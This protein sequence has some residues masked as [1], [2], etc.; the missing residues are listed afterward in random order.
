MSEKF[1]LDTNAFITPY[2]SFYDP[3]LVPSFWKAFECVLVSHKQVAVLDLVADEILKGDDSLRQWFDDLVTN[4]KITIISRKD[5]QIIKSY[6]HVMN[7]LQDSPLYTQKALKNWADS[8][9]ADPWLI[10]AAQVYGYTIITFETPLGNIDEKS[11]TSKP[12]IPNVGSH[13]GVPCQNL[14]YFMK[15]M[16]IKI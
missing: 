2:E 8:G 9:V 1:L 6:R 5:G 7:F 3:D 14:Y 10:A 11:P 13:F 16:K 4:Q 12:K 15:K